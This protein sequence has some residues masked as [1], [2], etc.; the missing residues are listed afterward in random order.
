LSPF[1]LVGALDGSVPLLLA[2]PH[3]GTHMPRAFLAG[4]RL[5]VP[6]LRRI[7]DA[8]VGLLLAQSA[9]LGI[10]LLEATHSRAVIDLNRAEDELDP[11]MFDAP[12]TPNPR[13]TDRV[14]RGYGL[15]PRVAGPNQPIHP[16]R[17]PAA[18][19]ATRIETLHRPWHDSIAHGLAAARANHGYA[20][21][22]D[23]HSMPTLEGRA[24]AQLVVGDLHGT[25]A[26]ARLVDWLEDCFADAGYRTARNHPYAGGYTTERHG[27][28][29][30][31]MHAVQLEFDRGLYM[32]MGTLKPNAGFGPLADSIA[33]IMAA[34]LRQLPHLRLEADLP[35]AAE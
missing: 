9:A 23:V 16:G 29:A 6:A 34:L 33:R 7:E 18:I 25:S 11:A 30:S 14:R 27:Q 2:S 5:S 3:S 20:V 10:P 26:S 1:Q 17:L 35:L 28:P 8:H 32:D 12:V 31:A 13:L 15:F 4:A 19:A 21:L 22:L 24:P